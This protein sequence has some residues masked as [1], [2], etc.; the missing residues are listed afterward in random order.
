M[1]TFALNSWQRKKAELYKTHE[2]KR[3]QTRSWLLSP[4]CSLTPATLKA[5]HPPFFPE[6]GT[7]FVCQNRE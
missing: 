5:L 6:Q 4:L 2:Q 3:E 1:K 7:L